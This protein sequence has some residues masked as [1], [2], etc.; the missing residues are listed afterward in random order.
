MVFTASQRNVG[1]PAQ[2]GRQLYL[3]LTGLRRR[4]K[5]PALGITLPLPSK[6]FTFGAGK[7]AR[8]NTRAPG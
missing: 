5:L 2:L 4:S 6:I 7:F 3:D 8:L 1:L